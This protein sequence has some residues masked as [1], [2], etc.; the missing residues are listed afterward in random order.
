MRTGP[1]ERGMSLLEAIVAMAI[2]AVVL[3]MA[4]TMAVGQQRT[5]FRGERFRA[6]QSS[7]RQAAL[8]IEGTLRRAG[9]GMDPALAFDFT[10]YGLAEPFANGALCP[11]D[12]D[13]C[14]RD[15][16]GNADELV[17]YSRNPYYEVA[18]GV[19][20][21]GKAWA[22]IGIAADGIDVAAGPT[23]RFGRGQILELVCGDPNR[24]AY[25]TVSTTTPGPAA[26]GPVHIPLEPV[27]ASDPFRRQ[28]VALADGC[29]LTATVFQ[30]DR[31]RYHV[32]PVQVGQVYG[33]PQYD[34][35]LVLDMGVDTDGDGDVDGDDEY[36]VA[37]GIQNLQ[38]AYQ[39]QN[40]ALADVGATPGTAVAYQAPAAQ[41]LRG[42]ATAG[43]ITTTDFP[44]AAPTLDR[45]IYQPSSW[46]SVSS[47]SQERLTNNQ[48]NIRAVRVSLLAQ[49]PTP[50]VQ[51]PSNIR[52]DANFSMLN[53]DP[54]SRAN[55]MTVPFHKPN[56]DDGYQRARVDTT[57]SIPNANVRAMIAY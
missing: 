18:T 40:G 15:S 16:V 38:V 39:F 46:Y 25:M 22:P 26:P 2:G 41:A 19:A 1:G 35:F 21:T 57:V 8:A 56:W 4:L 31:Y 37:G 32:R 50:D 6:A 24:Y 51:E 20:P 55:W 49:S 12:M 52:V 14:P 10:W 13:G 23:D 34:P 54:G 3:A 33:A 17:F 36:L 44:L 53:F 9:F 7:S 30:I 48:G 11:A 42:D 27:V 5:Y 45:S 29:F 43:T 28:D 47:S